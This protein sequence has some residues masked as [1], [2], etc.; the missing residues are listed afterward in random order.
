MYAYLHIPFC[1]AK[2]DYCD[3]FS[4][5]CGTQGVPDEYLSAL[6]AEIAFK[7][8]YYHVQKWDTVYLGGGTPSMLTAAQLGTCLHDVLSAVAHHGVDEVTV[9]MNP[10]SLTEEKLSAAEENGATRLSLGIQSLSPSCLENVHRHCTPEKALSAL[11]TVKRVW[12]GKLNT[13][14]IAGLP[15]P[16]QKES[17]VHTVEKLLSYNPDH[18]SL[19]TLMLEEGTPLFA[20]VE[21]EEARL[22]DDAD[23]LWLT[24]RGMLEEKGYVQYEVS[25][26]AKPGFESCHNFAYWR[27]ADYIGCG[28]GACG[29]MYNFQGQ[30]S[31]LTNTTD[32]K[33]YCAFWNGAPQQD[34]AEL[35][36]EMIAQGICTEEK[37]SLETEEFE[38]LMMGLRTLEGVSSETYRKRFSEVGPWYGDLGRRLESSGQVWEQFVK[39]AHVHVYK[40][41]QN[42]CRYALSKDGLLFLNELLRAL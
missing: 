32:V 9:E 26:F 12:Y 31:R 2:C 35:F 34:E 10:E 22:E 7:V 37:L 28:A 38:F 21:R 19:Y 40:N 15:G 23:K 33:K 20:R 16:N 11:D 3:F 24:G 18:F 5:P 29:T 27:Q 1:F 14:V 6:K 8:S 17:F 39:K 36:R 4:I 42:D 13:D 25:N 41:R 30:G